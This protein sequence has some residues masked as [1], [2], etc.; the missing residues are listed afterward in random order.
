MLVAD[1]AMRHRALASV[2]HNATID[3]N[4][5]VAAREQEAVNVRKYFVIPAL[6]VVSLAPSLAQTPSPAQDQPPAQVLPPVHTPS[7]AVNVEGLLVWFGDTADKV[8]EA[9]QTKLEPEPTENA[10]ARGTTSLRLKTKGV[11]FFFNRE[12]KIYT[13]RL[14][15]PFTGKINGVKIGDT[16]SKM[17]KVLG[18]PAKV[19]RP[20][21]GVNSNLLPRS[22][23]YYPDDVT[24]ANFQVNPDDEVE[25]VFLTK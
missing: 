7:P 14:E 6:F 22:Y 10:A 19:P 11:W 13:I 5:F 18:K 4:G 20:I 23:I 15:A 2:L 24:T 3:C 8:Q 9:Y 12:G 1:T 25:T 21:L 17:L 16:A